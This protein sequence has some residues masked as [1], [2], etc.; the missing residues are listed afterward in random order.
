[1]VRFELT[2]TGCKLT[3]IYMAAAMRSQD[4]VDF[5]GFEAVEENKKVLKLILMGDPKKL[6]EFREAYIHGRLSVDAK[7][8]SGWVKTFKSELHEKMRVGV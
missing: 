8:F 7:K 1:M 3:D 5:G 2:D 6:A 4:G